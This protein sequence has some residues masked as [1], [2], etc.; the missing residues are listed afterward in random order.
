MATATVTYFIILLVLFSAVL[1]STH[2]ETC[3]G[4]CAFNGNTCLNGGTCKNYQC[5]TNSTTACGTI[6]CFRPGH[7]CL[8]FLFVHLGTCTPCETSNGIFK[9]F[10][11]K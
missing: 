6:P 5:C 9:N 2:G 7:K 4:I 10:C 11:K 1:R 8:K 3:S